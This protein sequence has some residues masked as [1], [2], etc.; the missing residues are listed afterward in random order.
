MV[1]RYPITPVAK[2]R[3]TF[4]GKYSPRAQRYWEFKKQVALHKV[5]IQEGYS[6][7]LFGIPMP[8]SWSKKK[9]REMVGKPHQQ[10]PDLDNM[11][12]GL[13]DAIYDDDKVVWSFC[14]M[15]VWAKE[16]FISVH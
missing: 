11:I 4:K 9:K 7:I 3:I 13:C 16:G 8:K 1:I 14:A 2:P 12:K 10:A 6:H 15:K 5:K